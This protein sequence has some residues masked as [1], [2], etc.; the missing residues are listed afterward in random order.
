MYRTSISNRLNVQMVTIVENDFNVIKSH[1]IS[2]T[3]S[4][5]SMLFNTEMNGVPIQR[6]DEIRYNNH[7]TFLEYSYRQHYKCSSSHT[8]CNPAY[9]MMACIFAN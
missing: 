2:I 5:N 4:K 1:I 7:F 8:W 9:L 6:M 3:R